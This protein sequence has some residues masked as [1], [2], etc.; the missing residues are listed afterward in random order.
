MQ[1]IREIFE[2]EA[3]AVAAGFMLGVLGW[4]SRTL[5]RRLNAWNQLRKNLPGLG[6]KAGKNVLE[7]RD[8]LDELQLEQQQTHDLVWLLSNRHKRGDEVCVFIYSSHAGNLRVNQSYN[9][10]LGVFAVEHNFDFLVAKRRPRDREYLSVFQNF[11][12]GS[13]KDFVYPD[14]TLIP[15][16]GRPPVH[17]DVEAS[18]IRNAK[19][20][21]VIVVGVFRRRN[22]RPVAEDR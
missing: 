4:L 12:G 19:S 9:A 20:G 14:L 8:R 6:E 11:I 10:L 1:R 17:V 15:V 3:L 21:E 16:D 2:T 7:I 5:L 18:A 22:E 13:D